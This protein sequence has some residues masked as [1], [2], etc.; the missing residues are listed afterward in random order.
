MTIMACGYKA[1][2]N[3]LGPENFDRTVAFNNRFVIEDNPSTPLFEKTETNALGIVGTY[4]ARP[5]SYGDLC[6][7]E[8]L[9]WYKFKHPAGNKQGLN[10]V[11]LGNNERGEQ[12]YGGPQL[13]KPSTEGE[14]YQWLIED[15]NQP[16]NAADWAIIQK[17]IV[18]NLPS[19]QFNP[20]FN[21]PLGLC[22]AINQET[23]LNLS[24]LGLVSFHPESCFR[25]KSLQN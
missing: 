19:K 7:F 22:Y 13:T 16:R 12:V 20:D 5:L 23:P 2:L 11:F 24:Q 4:G 1:V 3:Y 10:C 25:L 17:A 8:N 6:R 21:T 18:E 9:L 14:I 15:Y